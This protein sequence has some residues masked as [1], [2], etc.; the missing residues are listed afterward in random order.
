[1]SGKLR[2]VVDSEVMRLLVA[3]LPP[4]VQVSPDS[5]IASDL[6]L[7]SAAIMDFVMELEDTLGISI[8]LDETTEI[9]TV[10]DLRRA[11]EALVQKAT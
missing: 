7:D 10:A 4:G 9:E 8:S 1:M 5:K 11:V 6:G 3:R 2:D